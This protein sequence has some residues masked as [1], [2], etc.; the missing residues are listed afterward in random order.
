MKNTY[1]KQP[2]E[3]VFGLR[4]CRERF[5]GPK[6]GSL[7]PPA[8]RTGCAA[9]ALR[10]NDPPQPAQLNSARDVSDTSLHTTLGSVCVVK[11]DTLG[12][13]SKGWGPPPRRISAKVSQNLRWDCTGAAPRRKPTSFFAAIHGGWREATQIC[14]LFTRLGASPTLKHCFLH[15]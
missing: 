8:G 4:S 13:L 5:G 6:R 7:A 12:A 15:G 2:F 1:P 11:T 3:S 10:R 14:M 9:A